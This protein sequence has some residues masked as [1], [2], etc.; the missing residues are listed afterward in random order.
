MTKTTAPKPNFSR[1]W[2]FASGTSLQPLPRWW[3]K[4]QQLRPL[5]VEVL[6]RHGYPSTAEHNLWQQGVSSRHIAEFFCLVARYGK[7]EVFNHYF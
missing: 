6:D 4:R 5:F 2:A 7:D 3:K 1:P